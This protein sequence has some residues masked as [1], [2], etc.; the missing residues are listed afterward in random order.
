MTKV[1][2]TDAKVFVWCTYRD[3]SFHVLEGLLDVSFWHCALIIT[4]HDCQY[5]LTLFEQKGIEILRIDPRQDLKE[6]RV[7]YKAI[8]LCS[9][10]VVFHYGWSWFVSTCVLDLCLNVTLHP[11]KLP[12]D[13]GGSPIQNQIRNGE[14]WTYANIIELASGLDEGDIF[15]R[16][17]ISLE[18]DEVDAVWA[19]MTATGIVLSRRFLTGIADKTIEPFLQDNRITPTIYKRVKPEDAQLCIEVQSARQ[20]YNIIRAHNETD[21]NSY[22]ARAYFERSNYRIVV[23]RGSL[24]KQQSSEEGRVYDLSTSC[25]STNQLVEI[26]HQV[27]N[28]EAVAFVIASDSIYVYLTRFRIVCK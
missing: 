11:G 23:E 6:G 18:G 27:N 21:P 15:L 12:K 13:R 2:E 3:W 9:P 14:T 25:H 19:R 16:E 8:K 1:V 7:G 24:S 5:D 17:K 28:S 10:D 26:A 4:A 20:I 22:V